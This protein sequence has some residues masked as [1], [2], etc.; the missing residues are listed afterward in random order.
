VNYEETLDYLYNTLP[1]FSRMGSA[2]F[3]KDLT[4]IRSLC[5]FLDNPQRKF[6]SIHV[7]GTNGKGSVSHMLSA[8]LQKAGYKTGL[9]TS[10]H[11][12]DFR[13][14]I[15]INGLM[16]PQ[17]FV[18]RFVQKIKHLIEEI[19]PSFFEITVAM[20]FDYFV[21]EQIEIAIIEVGL[22]GRLDSTNIINPEL[23]VITNIGWDH[24]NMLGNTLKEIAFEK[25]GIIK[26][27]IPVVIGEKDAETSQVFEEMANKNHAPLFFA[28]D[29]FSIKGFQLSFEHIA[30]SLH[31]EKGIYD[32]DY[33]LDLPGI[34]QTK[35]ILTLFRSLSLLTSWH[36]EKHHIY[37]AL[38]HIKEDTGLHGRWEVV[39]KNPTLILDVAHNKEGIQQ[40]MKHLQYVDHQNLHFV[41]GMVKDKDIENV[42]PLFPQN[43]SYY[44]TQAHIPRALDAVLLQHKARAFGL[45]GYCFENVNAAI[46]EA[47]RTA[48][49]DDLIIV[50]GSIFL[51][52]EANKVSISQLT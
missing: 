51:V 11:L 41:I 48:S 29:R 47:C 30:I 18:V 26:E 23:S 20:A 8:V 32:G 4:N 9:Y 45:K 3:K 22:G 13:E 35:N 43:A 12:Y 6:K 19:Q 27:N 38:R 49:E 44:F 28:E 50:C 7:G 25:A 37:E 40:M 21:C 34:Y 33:E 5:S 14:R 24:M 2:A 17:E 46:Q 39:Q 10:P 42:L 1:M 52:A 15:R 16:I 31:D 36:I